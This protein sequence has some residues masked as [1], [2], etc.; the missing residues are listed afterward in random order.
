MSA[1][2]GTDLASALN[3]SLLAGFVATAAGRCPPSRC[4]A[5]RG[6]PRARSPGSRR[7]LPEGFAVGAGV[8]AADAGAAAPITLGIAL[9]NAPEG[10]VVATSLLQ[11][12]YS[13]R[14]ALLVAGLTGLVEPLGAA[15]GWV[16]TALA[17]TMLPLGLA[18]A[19]GA[20]LYVVSGEVIPE[21]HRGEGARTATWGT[22]AGVA[23]MMVVDALAA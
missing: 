3:A 5:S 23:L 14:S 9:Q 20:M 13:R 7:G 11:E 12:R 15:L 19:A 6:E 4:R 17:A 8:G 21:S 10:L 2:A 18:F 16:A 22:M 1:V